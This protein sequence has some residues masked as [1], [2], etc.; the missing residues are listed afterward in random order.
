MSQWCALDGASVDGE[1]LAF[2]IAKA[3]RLIDTAMTNNVIPSYPL[4]ML[5]LL[6]A[7]SS[8]DQ[9]DLHASTYGYYYEL[10]IRRAL[11]RGA[12]KESFDLQISYL[13]WIAYRR[14]GTSTDRLSERELRGVHTA[15]EEDRLITLP[16]VPLLRQFERAEVIV[17]DGT[18]YRFAYPYIYYYFVASYVR[19]RITEPSIVALVRKLA[20]DVGN[21]DSAN[22][23]LFLAHLSKDPVVS[24]NLLRVARQSFSH[25]QSA[26]LTPKSESSHR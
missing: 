22:I 1:T 17:T 3:K 14:S 15:F 20:D 8:G 26:V 10:L 19:D 2:N 13:S 7:Y 18:D 23:I 11:A 4:F 12:T 6:Q 16:L 24:D 9:V 25:R 21:E 5:P